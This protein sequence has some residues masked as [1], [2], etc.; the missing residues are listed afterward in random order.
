MTETQQKQIIK[1][2]NLTDKQKLFIKKSQ[3]LYELAIEMGYNDPF[4]AGTAREIIMSLLLKHQ[5]AVTYM[6]EDATCIDT[7]IKC[8][9]KALSGKTNVNATYGGLTFYENIDD[10]INY[11]KNEKLGPFRHYIAQFNGMKISK[12]Y[13]LS[14]EKVFELLKDKV[15]KQHSKVKNNNLKQNGIKVYLTQTQ[16]I[17]N[18]KRIF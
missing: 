8:E 5:V 2:R 10:Q 16:V 15:I 9:Y 3:E 4:H 17:E 18:G 1:S 11:I 7:D 6:K 12:I 13:E 14:G